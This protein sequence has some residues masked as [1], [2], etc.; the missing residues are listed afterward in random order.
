MAL[1]LIT[2]DTI[3]S[4]N[5]CIEYSRGVLVERLGTGEFNAL[6]VLNA[7]APAE[8]QDRLWVIVRP[9]SITEAGVELVDAWVLSKFDQTSA[10]S[11]PSENCKNSW[12]QPTVFRRT[13]MLADLLRYETGSDDEFTAG[14]TAILEGI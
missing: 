6:Y 3:I 12:P 1:P 10:T 8:M 13:S 5:P 7:P 4:W 11:V 14:L 2:I 9:E